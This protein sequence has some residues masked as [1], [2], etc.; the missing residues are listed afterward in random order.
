MSKVTITFEDS[1]NEN[2]ETI[3]MFAMSAESNE[4]DGAIP[5]NGVSPA[6]ALGLA[7]RDMWRS[8][9]LYAHAGENIEQLVEEVVLEG[10]VRDNAA[11]VASTAAVK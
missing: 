4:C 3:V 6:A 2:N 8:G 7:T 9:A 1:F 10:M 5:A 11:A